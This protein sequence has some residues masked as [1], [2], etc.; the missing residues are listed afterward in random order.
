[1]IILCATVNQNLITE[2]KKYGDIEPTKCFNCGNCT[3]LCLHSKE[4][5]AFPRKVIR[6]IQL[7]LKNKLIKAPEPWLCDYCGDCSESCPRQANPGEIMMSTRRYLIAQYDWTGLS[8][9]FYT[10]IF[11]EIGSLIILSLMIL[12]LFTVSGSFSRMNT[13][14]VSINT[15]APV[16]WVHFGDLILFS[17]LALLLLSNA[18]RMFYFIILKDD[19]KIPFSLY[20][21]EFKS[22]FLSL[23]TQNDWFKCSKKVNWFKHLILVTAYATMFLLVV[24]LLP[25]FQ[26]DGPVWHWTSILGYYATFALLYITTDLMYRRLRK[27]DPMHKNS[28]SSD[29]TFLMLLFLT[30]LSG[31]FLHIFR[32]MNLPLPAYYMYIIHLMIAVPMLIIE[33]PFGKWSHMLYRPLATFLAAVKVQAKEI[34]S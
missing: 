33:V 1:M 16:M 3:A 12:L 26:I 7:G 4:L 24:V 20:L 5:N 34:Q 29:W 31:I 17:I 6:Y 30:S 10:S 21:K 18:V 28:H 2:I 11:W 32:I 23:G 13:S 14:E 15:F 25:I 22:F 27:T 8:K 9:K 19:V